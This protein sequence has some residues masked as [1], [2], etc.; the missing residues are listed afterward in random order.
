MI[1][2]ESFY[3]QHSAMRNITIELIKFLVVYKYNKHSCN[4][5][6]SF[7][8]HNALLLYKRELSVIGKLITALK[9]ELDLA[10]CG[11]NTELLYRKPSLGPG[12]VIR[13]E[14]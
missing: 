14:V 10:N 1:I 5:W 8:I 11:S 13:F 9:T 3:L 12:K 7:L 6:I 2:Q 4:L